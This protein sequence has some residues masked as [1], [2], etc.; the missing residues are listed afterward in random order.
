[1]ISNLAQMLIWAA[2]LLPLATIAFCMVSGRIS[3][4]GLL[5]DGR[6]HSPTRLFGFLACLLTAL[7]YLR[8]FPQGLFD[9]HTAM[10]PAMPE[11]LVGLLGAAGSLYLGGKSLSLGQNP[12]PTHLAAFKRRS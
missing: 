10:L 5:T 2:A 12:L 7:E 11:T 3:M 4:Q 8:R 1:M 6:S 9:P